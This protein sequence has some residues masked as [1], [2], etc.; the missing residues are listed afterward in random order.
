MQ[1]AKQQIIDRIKDSANVLVTVNANPTVDGLAAAIGVTLL[2]NKMGKHAST[3]FSGKIPSTIEFLQPEKTIET[4]TDSLRDFIIALDKAKADKLRY[5][6]ED[7]LVKIFITPYRT[8]INEKDL[9][10]SQGDFNVDLV[11]ALGVKRREELDQ[12]ITAHG[13]ILHDAT[14]ATVNTQDNGQLGTINWVDT[15]A[16]SICEMMTSVLDS[17]Q[18]NILDQQTATALLTGI[19]AETDRFSNA[20]TSS[21]TMS[22]SAKLMAAGANQQ[23]VATKL[24]PP[25]SPSSPP[26]NPGPN[27]SNGTGSSGSTTLRI[28]PPKPSNDGTLTID[29]HDGPKLDINDILHPKENPQPYEEP[30]DAQQNPPIEQIHID[31]QGQFRRA[32]EDSSDKNKPAALS[33]IET[34]SGANSRLVLN[35]PAFGGKLTSNTEPEHLDPS[36]DP[37]AAQNQHSPIIDRQKSSGDGLSLPPLNTGDTLAEIEEEVHSS[38]LSEN[39]PQNDTPAVSTTNTSSVDQARNAVHQAISTDPNP[40]SEPL[41]AIGAQPVNINL[42]HNQPS[43]QIPISEQGTDEDQEADE[44]DNAMF[45]PPAIDLPQAQPGAVSPF[46]SPPA[47][48]TNLVPLAKPTD[49]T[50]TLGSPLPP[51]PVPPPMTMPP[52]N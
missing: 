9:E 21:D 43:E 18:A 39:I 52:L 37:L 8:S 34:P 11:L 5:K 22:I 31:E 46:D 29:H 51:P 15:K 36:I 12:A 3:V 32:T 16:S 45:P 2:L 40:P 42:E 1:D 10:F 25:S 48:P 6:V 35:P 47:L 17:I 7:K 38:H 23:L 28:V 50:G 20:K 4:N 33:H 41:A 44:E 30:T 14:V 49:T 24:T 19:V 27:K 13:R 26:S